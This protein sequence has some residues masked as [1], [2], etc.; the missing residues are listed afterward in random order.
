MVQNLHPICPAPAPN[1][2]SALAEA[3]PKHLRHFLKQKFNQS[4][5]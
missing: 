1:S 2:R 5:D 4:F 3:K